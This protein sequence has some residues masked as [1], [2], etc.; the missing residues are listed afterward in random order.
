M[1]NTKIIFSG[2]CIE[3]YKVNNYVI[4][5]DKKTEGSKRIDRILKAGSENSKRIKD[6]T[7]VVDPIGREK[8]LNKAK[9][10]IIRLIRSND[11]MQTFITLTFKNELDYKQSKAKLNIFFTKL[12]KVYK[13]LKYLWVLEYGDKNNRLHYHVLCNIPIGIKLSNSKERKSQDHK[14]LE[15]EFNQKYWGYGFVDIRHLKAEENNNVALYV[16]MYIVKSLKDLSLEGYRVYGYSHKTLNKPDELK[17]YSKE[18]IEDLIKKYCDYKIKYQNNYDIGFV[19]W[20]REHKGN[21]TYIELIKEKRNF[22]E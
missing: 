8:T 20:K 7:G 9:N 3:I 5:E 12:R 15:Q 4:R 11:D 2:D 13:N 21:V 18:T 17:Y 6:D 1:Y 22:N 14:K 16:S 19:D 10:N